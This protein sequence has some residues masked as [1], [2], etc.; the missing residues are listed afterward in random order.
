MPIRAMRTIGISK[1]GLTVIALL[2]FVL[3]G[4]IFA[5]RALVAKARRDYDH[6]RRTQPVQAPIHEPSTPAAMPD[7]L[8]TPGVHVTVT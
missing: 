7:T 8:E 5:E 4:V 2:V 1:Q 3:W 6:F